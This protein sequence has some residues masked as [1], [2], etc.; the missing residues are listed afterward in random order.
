LPVQ[1]PI[2]TLEVIMNLLDIIAKNSRVY[3]DE[4]A[5]VEL[6]P[7]T[8]ARKEI[9]WRRFE[10]RVNKIANAHKDTGDLGRM[11]GEGFV[12]IVDRKKDLPISGGGRIFTL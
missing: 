6:K 4:S 11:D 2:S 10:E 5:F 9:S 3:P 1:E 12:Y 8:K 7:V